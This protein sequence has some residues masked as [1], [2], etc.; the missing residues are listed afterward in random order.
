MVDRS[1]GRQGAADEARG[2]R[3][4]TP[5]SRAGG[6]VSAGRRRERGGRRACPARSTAPNCGRWPSGACSGFG[7]TSGPPTL[8][9]YFYNNL[10]QIVQ[11][12]DTVLILNEMV[13][14]ARVIRMNAAAPAVEHPP[15]D[16]RFGRHA[17]KATRSSSTRP[18]SPARP[19]SAAR[20]RTC[21]SSSA[22]RAPTRTP[23]S[24]ASR[25]TIRRRGTGRGPASIR[26][27]RPNE[28]LYEYACHEGNYSLGGML[29]GARQKEAED[30]AKKSGNSKSAL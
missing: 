2:A 30:A 4:E 11:T 15:V 1:A 10:K 29:R 22:S 5:R 20:A 7:S 6:A 14:D 26:G 28:N 8:P 21:T 12:K 27:T 18:T 23:S 13:H 17:G 16:G 24:T 9:N 3:R 19:S 25:S